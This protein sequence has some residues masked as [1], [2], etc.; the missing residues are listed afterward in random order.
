MHDRYRT[1]TSFRDNKWKVAYQLRLT[2]LQAKAP[3]RQKV[4]W[5][6]EG[7]ARVGG[8]IDLLHCCSPKLSSCLG[9]SGIRPYRQAAEK[10]V[11]GKTSPA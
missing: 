11:R 7:V 3:S 10:R 8:P 9:G 5:S 1:D 2:T 4:M 6:S